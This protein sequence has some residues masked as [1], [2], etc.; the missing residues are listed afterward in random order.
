M[1]QRSGKTSLGALPTPSKNGLDSRL[2]CPLSCLDLDKKKAS[3]N[4]RSGFVSLTSVL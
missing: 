1:E 2:E 3:R 4:D